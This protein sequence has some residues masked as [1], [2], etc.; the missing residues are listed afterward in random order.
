MQTDATGTVLIYSIHR[1]EAWFRHLGQN[2]G[3]AKSYVVSDLP[4]EGDYNLVADFQSNQRKFYAANATESD[5]L[6]AAEVREIT[7]RCRVLRFM[8]ARRA[9]SMTLAMAAAFDK[10]ITQTNPTVIFSFP[11]D[12]YI[13]DVLECLGK[14]RGIPYYELTVSALPEMSML[15]KKGVLCK[16]DTQP[17]PALVAKYVD[18]LVTPLFTPSYVQGA[19]KFTQMRFL[20]VFA[21]F[22]VRGFFF[23]LMSLW[24]RDRLNLHYLDAQSFLGHKPSFSD[25]DI[26]KLVDQGW[27]PKVEAFD[28]EKRIFFGLQLFPEASID[29]WIHN[30]DLIEHEDVVVE[31]AKTFSDAG[32][33]V[34]IKDHPLQYGFRQIGLINRLLALPNVVLVPYEVS[35]NAVLAMCG[36]NFTGTGT[37]GLQAALL[38]LKSITTEN[39]YTTPG[40]FILLKQR[41]DIARLPAMVAAMPVPDDLPVRQNRIIANLMQG[42]F[43]SDFFSFQKFDPASPS[44]GATELGQLL[45][46]E[47][48]SFMAAESV[49]KAR[50]T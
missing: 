11:I 30:L 38:G 13:M 24:H 48:R 49:N 35:G 19:S 1:T 29:Y 12:R 45:G 22:R 2:M 9:A 14:A 40:D 41:S 42:S 31:T 28:K 23:W 17:D 21:Y 36:V 6:T 46:A 18:A 15:L 8:G 10:V 33:V 39:Y 3:F 26:T 32:Y 37:L 43:E 34:V 50:I 25:R 47:L 27:R 20:K 4:G 16:H 44:T 5:L 7:A